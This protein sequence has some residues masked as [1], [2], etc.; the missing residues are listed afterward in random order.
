LTYTQASNQVIKDQK[1]IT[2]TRKSP[3]A[4]QEN[5]TKI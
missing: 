2:T 3:K 4:K 5:H 1:S